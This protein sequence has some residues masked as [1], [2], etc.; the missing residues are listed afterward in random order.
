MLK[1]RNSSKR[2][3][4]VTD[5]S[6]EVS[7]LDQIHNN[8]IKEFNDISN[9]IANL[10]TNIDHLKKT[11]KHLTYNMKKVQDTASQY[12]VDLW[13]SNIGIKEKLIHLEDNIKKLKQ[14]DAVSYYDKNSKLLFRYYDIVEKNKISIGSQKR[15]K[16]EPDK[17]NI[18]E[19]LCIDTSNMV[20][21]TD[22][23]KCC[24]VN[25]YLA[26]MD[27]KYIENPDG[28][29]VDEWCPVCEKTK[30]TN[31]YHDAINICME[32]GYQDALLVEQN[33]P[34]ISQ[35]TKENSHYSYKRINHFREWCNQLQGKE[36]TDIPA[37]IFEKILNE[38]KK[39]KIT[40]LKSLN[41]KTMRAIL[42]K[43]KI[44]RYYEHSN[45][46]INRINGVSTPQF[47]PEIE[48]KLCNMFKEIQAP[49]AK[50]SSTQRKNFLSYS[51]TLYKFCQLLGLNEFLPHLQLLK[52]RTK[53]YHQDQ[54][55][56][57]IC[58]DCNLRFIPTV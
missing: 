11:Q 56:K 33:K 42:K 49:F 10:Q 5:K 1:E 23:E 45:Y 26:K 20:L 41:Y 36:S 30:L 48:E 27:N 50:H 51:Y 46:I 25:K 15:K 54:L 9:K 37:H 32:C 6:K 13:N 3:I 8:K 39:E 21:D 47:T 12:A 2:R 18:L 17:K 7:T 34:A 52:S 38:I 28:D 58:V 44:H 4:T 16:H 31:V 22:G 24:L 29:C 35:N 55:W 57:K 43:L 14:E 53:M 40:D 19:A